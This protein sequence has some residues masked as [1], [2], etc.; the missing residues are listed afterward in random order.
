MAVLLLSSTGCA[1]IRGERVETGMVDPDQADSYSTTV[2]AN[3]PA[4][5][6]STVE[7]VQTISEQTAEWL[8]M[9]EAFEFFAPELFTG[10]SVSGQDLYATG[11]VLMT[12]VAPD[13]VVSTQ[14]S[15][16]FALTAEEHLSVTFVF[17]HTNGDATTYERFVEDADLYQQN[18]IHINDSD[19]TLWNR[20][21]IQTQPSSVLVKR[22][23]RTAVTD[24]GLG[25]DGLFTAMELIGSAE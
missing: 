25:H 13:C 20:F 11:P 8:V 2:L 17:V 3:E 1:A 22:D 18:V 4:S 19:L 6:S 12:F 14:D 15:E 24:G 23:G 7:G 16:A 10:A 9:P 21:G 5:S